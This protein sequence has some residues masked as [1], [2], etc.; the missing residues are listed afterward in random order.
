M[1]EEMEKSDC[2]FWGISDHREVRPDQTAVAET[3]LRETR[4]E[5]QLGDLQDRLSHQAVD[6]RQESQSAL[7]VSG[8]AD[9]HPLHRLQSAAPGMPRGESGEVMPRHIQSHFIAVRSRMLQ[10][11]SFR[12]YWQTM[13]DIKKYSDSI[14]IHETR[15][16]E[17]FSDLGFK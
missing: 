10:S 1:F 5:Q 13:P 11:D 4:I 15:F 8:F 9:F 6:S 14:R 7:A 12:L 17:H 16:T 2:D 3:R